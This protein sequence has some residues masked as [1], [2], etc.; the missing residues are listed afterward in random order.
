M[1]FVP[2]AGDI[3]T[4]NFDPQAGKEM[5]KRRPA[6]VVSPKEFNAK[7]G[8]AWVCP[9]TSTPSRHAFHFSLPVGL[10]FQGT[11]VVEQ[12]R[13]LDFRAR[14]AQSES[15]V[16]KDFLDDIRNVIGRIVFN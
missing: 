8:F 11:V 9:I 15:V 12:L 3:I 7:M 4:L 1:S 6:L 14:S 2:A 16:P 5:M 10:G 13:S